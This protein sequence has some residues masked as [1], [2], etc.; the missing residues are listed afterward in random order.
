M[1]H[2]EREAVPVGNPRDH[3]HTSRASI[4]NELVLAEL[5][6][7]GSAGLGSILMGRVPRLRRARDLHLHALL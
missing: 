4:S 1:A 6:G 7:D 5:A 2:L 3:E